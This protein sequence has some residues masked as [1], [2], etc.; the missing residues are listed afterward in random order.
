MQ[1]LF[2]RSCKF[3]IFI[4]QFGGIVVGLVSTVAG[5]GV[6]GFADG[7]GSAALFCYPFG[8]AV[9]LN[10]AVFIA[11]TDNHRVRVV[12]TAGM[13]TE[14]FDVIA[15]LFLLFVHVFLTTQVLS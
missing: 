8:I 4:F 14:W 6:C 11:S 12:S 7:V 9:A 13:G 3:I 15:F 5:S 10:G 1:S 2:P